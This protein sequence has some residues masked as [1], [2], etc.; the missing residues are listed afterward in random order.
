MPANLSRTPHGA[1]ELPRPGSCCLSHG[2]KEDDTTDQPPETG[3]LGG[4]DGGPKMG[5]A[6][7]EVTLSTCG[8]SWAKG[9]AKEGHG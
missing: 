7:L 6:K 3:A 9:T 2:G 8:G 1:R 5:D 4:R